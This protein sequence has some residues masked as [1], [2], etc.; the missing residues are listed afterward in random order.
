MELSSLIIV[1]Q[2]GDTI[3]VYLDLMC[4]D[5]ILNNLLN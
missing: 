3:T 5:I 4:S 2:K 1:M